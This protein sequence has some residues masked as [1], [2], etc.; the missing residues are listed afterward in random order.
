M[1]PRTLL[2]T[3]A[4]FSS[5]SLLVTSLMAVDERTSSSASE[6]A[7]T[8]EKHTAT[9]GHMAHKSERLSQLMGTTVKNPQ[10]ETLGQLNDFVVDPASG[11]IQF[12]IISLND[13][14]QGGKLTAVPWSLARM[15][16]EPNSIVL[17]VDK[18]KLASAQT[19]DA[20]SWP[21]FNQAEWSQ[22]TYSHFGV[23]EPSWKSM[24]GH[25]PTSRST[26]GTDSSSKH[27]LDNGTAPDGHGTFNQ[28]PDVNPQNQATPNNQDRNNNP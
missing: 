6:N 8:Q 11:R 18:Q 23:S 13:P 26:T 21:D 22:K 1:K 14:S 27:S 16:A 3:I 2:R 24:G 19:F 9:F 28:G 15:G 10:G 4:L 5:S 25:V 17:N 20:T 7:P 12:A